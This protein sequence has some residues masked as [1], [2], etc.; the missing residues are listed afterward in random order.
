MKRWPTIPVAPSMPMGYLFCMALNTPVYRSRDLATAKTREGAQPPRS[1]RNP[2]SCS[3]LSGRL[4]LTRPDGQRRVFSGDR[5][6]FAHIPPLHNSVGHIRIGL[7]EFRRD[8][9]RLAFEEDHDTVHRIG[10]RAAQDELAALDGL[11]GHFEVCIAELGTAGNVVFANFVEEKVMHLGGRVL[12]WRVL[13]E[14]YPIAASTA[15]ANWLV[16]ATPP[17]SRVRVLRSA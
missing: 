4:R 16:P 11:P 2:R 14:I 8:L 1:G 17:T 5:R 10:Q 6:P 7:R 13:H 12:S 15:S 3:V 9:G